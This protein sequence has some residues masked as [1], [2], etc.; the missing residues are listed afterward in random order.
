VVIGIARKRQRIQAQGV[1][2]GQTQQAQIRACGGQMRQVVGDQ[3]MTQDEGG[4]FGQ[5]IESGQCGAQIVAAVSQ[6]RPGIA[7]DRGELMD[8]P[9]L[10][11]D[12]QIDAQATGFEVLRCR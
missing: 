7:P 4:A 3:V 12:F 6:R 1:D 10:D 8:A 11:A 9:I 5:V 2:G